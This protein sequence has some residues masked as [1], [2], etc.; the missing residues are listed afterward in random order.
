[1]IRPA[2][3]D[4]TPA[5]VALAISTGLFQPEEADV[6]LRAVLDDL[7]GGRLGPDHVA[8]VWC[9]SAS[10]AP[11]GWAYFSS[12]EKADRVWDL[13]WIGVDP[14]RHGQGVGDALL[15]FVESEV[16]SRGGRML[17][18][19]TSSLPP[20]ARARRFYEKRGY[21]TCGR[22]PDFYGE[23]DDK[24]VYVARTATAL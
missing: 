22:V 24:V 14:A 3:P 5:L 10:A 2:A 8:V 17:L 16:R 1:M 15:S 18:I 9:A 23:G 6:L 12:N 21:A 7:H 11:S 20:T 13:W 19:E 4:D